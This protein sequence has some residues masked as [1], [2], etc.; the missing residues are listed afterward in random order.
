MQKAH[1]KIDIPNDILIL[2]DETESD[3]ILDMKHYTAAFL[4]QK[5][6]LTIGKA[7]ELAGMSRIEFEQF[8][9]NNRLPISNLTI[10]DIHNDLDLLEN[11]N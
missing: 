5:G 8:L 4:F 10:D 11:I 2:L 1:L 3:F 9:G 6:K 7:A